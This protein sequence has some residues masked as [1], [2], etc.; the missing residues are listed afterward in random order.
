MASARCGTPP[1]PVDVLTIAVGV[2]AGIALADAFRV[3]TIDLLER[4]EQYRL[5]R[6]RQRVT[7][8]VQESVR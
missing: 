6:I 7:R 3:L 4:L 1:N 5:H 8:Q 2:G